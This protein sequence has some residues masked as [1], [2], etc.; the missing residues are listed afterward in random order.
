MLILNRRTYKWVLPHLPF[1]YEIH[2]LFKKKDR[3]LLCECVDFPN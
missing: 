3:T 1:V 2:F